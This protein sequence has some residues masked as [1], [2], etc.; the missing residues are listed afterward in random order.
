MPYLFPQDNPSYMGPG[1]PSRLEC[2]LGSLEY[3][4]E[5]PAGLEGR[6]YRCGPDPQFVPR[7]RDDVG[8]NGDGM[9]S[10]FRFSQGR[11]DFRQ[12]YVRTDKF[13][14]ERAAG[15]A[16]FGHYR[17]RFTDDPSV[18]GIDRTTANTSMVWH[19]GRLFAVKED[20]LPHELDP[21]TLETRGKFNFEGKLRS[22]HF[23]AHPKLDPVTGNLVFYGFEAAGDATPTISY[24][25]ADR[26]LRLLREQWFDAPYASMIHDFAVTQN[27]VVFPVMPTASDLE[28]MKAG[29][30]HFAWDESL[31][32]WL[33]VVPRHGDVSQV[34]WF[35]G[36]ARWSFHTLNAFEEGDRLH[37]DLTVSEINGFAY[38][39]AADGKA[40]DPRRARSCL[41]R[42]TVNLA[43]GSDQFSERLL[44]DTP[45]DFYKTDPRAQTLPYRHGFMA[46]RDADRPPVTRA[47]MPKATFNTLA[48]IDH[49]TGQVD[50]WWAGEESTTQEPQFVPKGG[51]AAEGEGWLLGVIG[52]LAEGRSDLVVLDA[53][54]LAAGPVATVRLPIYLRM[55][56]HGEWV[57]E[58]EIAAAAARQGGKS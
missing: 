29:G 16:L 19:G 1:R 37:I 6:F 23:T 17:N 36:P 15:R 8:I 33:G 39:P 13:N 26:D 47:L 25:E 32:T 31:P 9:V 30:F 3:E 22:P 10:M 20:G 54:D 2:E 57:P 58:R 46:A 34:R 40:W 49:A 38:I 35:K 21:D 55:T 45:S 7:F 14:T 51:D 4:G 27:Y 56:F 11:V 48:R 5:L 18:A 52:R 24:A 41:T 28:R 12:R 42:W 53:L 44:W 43:D 50:S